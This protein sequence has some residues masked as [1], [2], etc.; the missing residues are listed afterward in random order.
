M[1]KTIIAD[2]LPSVNSQKSY[3][4]KAKI[5]TYRDTGVIELLSYDTIVAQ[6]KDGEF[7]V[8]GKYSRTTTKHIKDFMAY[9]G[10]DPKTLV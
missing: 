3:Y 6:Y 4:G 9:L 8:N 7:S 10:L 1:E 5:I 2:L